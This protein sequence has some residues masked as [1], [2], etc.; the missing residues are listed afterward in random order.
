[1]AATNVFVT[2]LYVTNLTITNLFF[3]NVSTTNV[4]I[5]NIFVTNVILT[6]GSTTNPE[7]LDHPKDPDAANFVAQNSLAIARMKEAQHYLEVDDYD[8][9]LAFFHDALVSTNAEVSSQVLQG[10]RSALE[11]KNSHWYGQR[12]SA[13]NT[14]FPHVLEFLAFLALFGLFA[15]WRY[16]RRNKWQVTALNEK[17][18]ALSATI[19]LEEFRF[20]FQEVIRLHSQS[21]GGLSTVYGR[22]P[23]LAKLPKLD[24]FDPTTVPSIGVEDVD[25]WIK[26]ALFLWN[27]C[28]WRL[29]IRVA[30]LQ[31]AARA[32]AELR[33]G[34]W[35]FESWRVDP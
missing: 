2:N 33:W 34:L 13:L 26:V 11:R 8:K 18:A 12:A 25:K 15:R 1:M 30:D 6:N 9:A 21:T 3:T 4:T 28:S 27:L 19:F 31:T 17:D 22:D 32:Y 24:Q 5:T 14:L 7:K 20:S 16:L 29:E 23:N 35:R 10:I